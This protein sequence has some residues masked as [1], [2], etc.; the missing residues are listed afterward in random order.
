MV[1]AGGLLLL[2][3][4]VAWATVRTADVPPRLA[5]PAPT[6]APVPGP[7]GAYPEQLRGGYDPNARLV[8]LL[9]LVSPLLTTIVGF[10]FGQRAGGAQADAADAEKEQALRAVTQLAQQ[11]P[12]DD[13]LHELQA[14]GLAR[15]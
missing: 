11:A 5:D 3:V 12:G 4:Y 6:A 2:F 7:D 1:L 13:F 10:Y 8:G 14:R 15:E 9:A